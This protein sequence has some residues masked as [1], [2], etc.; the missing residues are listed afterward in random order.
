MGEKQKGRKRKKEEEERERET[1]KYEPD[2]VSCGL[3]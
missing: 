3:Q 1:P 2:S